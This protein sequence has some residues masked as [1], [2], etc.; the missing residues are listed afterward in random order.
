MRAGRGDVRLAAPI[1]T[2]AAR[3][4]ESHIHRIIRI[5]IADAATVP[6]AQ[7]RAFTSTYRDDILRGARRADAARAAR[8]ASGKANEYLLITRLRGHGV[9]RPRVI[10]LRVNRIRIVAVAPAIR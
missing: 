8:I 3:R 2:G 1:I 9:A 6:A 10:F 7:T 4:E 5:H